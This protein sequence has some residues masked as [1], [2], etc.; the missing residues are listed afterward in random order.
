[1]PLML[2]NIENF[3]SST[4]IV[5][6]LD[7]VIYQMFGNMQQ[8]AMISNQ[9]PGR[10]RSKFT[11]EEDSKL[12]AIVQQY[13]TSS[14]NEIATMFPGKTVRQVRDR[15]KNY[16][17]PELN[18]LPW[19]EFEDNLLREQFSIHGPRWSVLKQFF[20]NRTDVSIKNRWSVLVSKCQRAQFNLEDARSPIDVPRAQPVQA[21]EPVISAPEIQSV[22]SATQSRRT[23]LEFDVFDSFGYGGDN[24]FGDSVWCDY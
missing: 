3:E 6:N 22:P 10:L 16:L 8:L 11:V 5:R 1:M 9:I 17:S 19:T 18:H 2:S 12:R 13:P 21:V 20:V 24:L 14:W 23:S 15:Y 7:Q 4:Q